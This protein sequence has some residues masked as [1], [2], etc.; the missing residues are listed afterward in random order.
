MIAGGGSIW[1]A[2]MRKTALTE[3]TTIPTSCPPIST[4]ITRVIW[5]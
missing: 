4:T 5:P 1:S 3:S 2:G